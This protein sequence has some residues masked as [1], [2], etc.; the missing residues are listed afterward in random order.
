MRQEKDILIKEKYDQHQHEKILSRAE[1]ESDKNNANSNFIIACYDLQAVLPTPR[2]E[3]SV[4][5]YKQKFNSY[6]FTISEL[7]SD[8]VECYF[9]HEG[10]GKRGS[11]KIGTC[12][13][14]FLE[15]ISNSVNSDDLEIVLYSENCCGQQKNR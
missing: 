12:V 6:N 3:V 15:G 14:K 5:Y 4:F 9:W 8:R 10:L 7:K 13:Y 1:K 11:N 2:G